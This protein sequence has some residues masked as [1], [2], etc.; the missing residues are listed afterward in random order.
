MIKKSCQLNI[1]YNFFLKY[2]KFQFIVFFVVIL[3]MK[4]N[5]SLF[6]KDLISG[7]NFSEPSTKNIQDDDFLNPGFLWVER[8]KELWKEKHTENSKLSCENCHGAINSMKGVSLSFPKVI[9]EN[10]KLINLEQQINLCRKNKMNLDE[11]NPESKNL[12]SLSV[13]ISNQ[14]RGLKQKIEITDINRKW[15]NLGKQLYFQK[16]GQMG[17]A[18]NQCHDD[19]VGLNLRAEKVSQ[20]HINGFPSYLLRWSKVASVHRRIQFC[21]EQARASPFKIF[22][23]EYNALQLYLSHRGNGLV[24]ET[25]AVRK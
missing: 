2:L 14:S 25:P 18:C 17:L 10:N 11:Y 5:F 13:A 15:Y 1:V 19:R 23:D 20:G 12:L 22:S 3:Y 6:S 4:T 16:V 7:Y 24:I 21:N 8:G 9:K